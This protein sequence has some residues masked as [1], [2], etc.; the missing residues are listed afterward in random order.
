M[1]ARYRVSS[2][3]IGCAATGAIA[4]SGC[5]ASSSGL[6]KAQLAAKASAICATYTNAATAIRVP[7]DINTNPDSVA[8]FLDKL[9]PLAEAQKSSI[10]ALKPASD[11][12]SLWDQFVAAGSRATALLEDADAKAHAKDRTG[13]ND[14]RQIAAIH[15]GTIVPLARQL[16]ATECAK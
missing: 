6:S 1:N 9:K 11:V 12:K 15:Q 5:G 4:L 16:G 14:L 8:A 2:F 10:L 7:S 3:G 13:L